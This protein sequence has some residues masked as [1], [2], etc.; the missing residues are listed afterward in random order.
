MTEQISA[1]ETVASSVEEEIYAYLNAQKPESFFLFAGAGSG[2]TR[3]LVEVLKRLGAERGRALW[4]RGQRI[5]V[6]TYTNAACD[7][8][9]QRLE[10]D[11]VIKVSTIHSFA[12]SL[13]GGFHADI[14][15]WLRFNLAQEIAEIEEKQKTGRATSQAARDRER[16]IAN[17]KRRLA[18]LDTI[19]CFVYSPTGDNR[20]RDSLNHSEVIGI[21]SSFLIASPAFSRI[22]TN[23]FPIL[24]IDESQDTNK[25]LLNALIAVQ[26]KYS[27]SFSIGLFGDTMQR[28]YSDGK[29]DLPEGLPTD[30]KRPE[31]LINYRSP[32][33][34]VELI[35]QIRSVADDHVQ[36]NRPEKPGG[37]VRLFIVSTSLSDQKPTIETG[38]AADMAKIT[39]DPKWNGPEAEVKTLTLEHH[40]AG[41][42]MGF[43]QVFEPLYAVDALKTGLLE[44]SLPGLRLFTSAV[45]PLVEAKQRGDEFAVAAVVRRQ[46]PL[47]DKKLLKS[48]GAEQPQMLKKAQE[49][50]D[51]LMNLWRDSATPLLRDVLRVISEHNLFELPESLRTIAARKDLEGENQDDEDTTDEVD[52]VTAAW[53]KFLAAPYSQI[54]AYAKYLAGRSPFTTHQGVKGLEFPR[55]MVIMDDDE[56][57]GFLFSYDKLT[58]AKSKSDTDI[59]NEQEGKETSIDRTRRLFYVTC[60]RAEESLAVVAYSSSPEEVKEHVLAQGWFEENEIV[61]IPQA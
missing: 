2:K 44:G 6:I 18:D 5:G 37:V 7:E 26:A 43:L 42:R 52:D 49:S 10:F 35:N 12:W 14:R 8:I 45:L 40:M 55:V 30:W 21:T 27:D 38:I 24:L 19:K 58:G 46:S 9:K 54:L 61:V 41:R 48:A 22:L 39:G 53:E 32:A 3:S 31:K 57:R 59:K 16:K 33:R 36:K 23:K 20:G 1:S 47:L 29:V 28:I 11:P 15:E 4:L 13:T 60:S 34:I 50:V 56:A 17:K 25:H 51:A